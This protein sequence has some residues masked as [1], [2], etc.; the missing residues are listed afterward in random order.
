MTAMRRTAVTTLAVVGL[1]LTA[2]AARTSA[3]TVPP[4]AAAG[5]P[6]GGCTL[7]DPAVLAGLPVHEAAA[8]LP[9][10]STFTAAVAA[11]SLDDQLAGA[12]PFTIFAPSN[13]AMSEIPTNVLDS[14]L[15]DPELL[16]SI[17]GYHIVVGEALPSD[18]LFGDLPT[19]NGTLSIAVD[20]DTVVINA[21]EATVVCPDVITADATIHVI[22]HVLQ[23]A[24]E[25]GCPDASSSVPGSS[26]PMAST[27][28]SSSPS[29]STPC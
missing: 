18:M 4:D 11:S 10:L 3:T 26:A 28:D 19:L 14:L 29:S 9:E 20:G 22:D 25:S 27:P 16:D 12:G 8:Q 13:V 1:S 2:V 24:G 7:Y 17:L 15:A 5:G 21:G 6:P 23:P